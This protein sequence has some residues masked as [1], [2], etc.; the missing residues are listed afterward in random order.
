MKRA[1]AL[2]LICGFVLLATS[3]SCAAFDYPDG[4]CRGARV[5]SSAAAP[6]STQRDCASCVE[7]SCCDPV[8]KCEDDGPS[9]L[10]PL[11]AM[12]DCVVEGG[13]KPS[14]EAKC[15]PALASSD[16]AKSTYTCMRD[17]CGARCLL[18]ACHVDPA[19][20]LILHSKCDQC[21]SDS[22]CA[23]LNACHQNRACKLTSECIVSRCK[24]QLA[25]SL[26]AGA[27]SRIG[28][29][30]LDEDPICTKNEPPLGAF[31]EG[32]ERCVV[33][34]IMEFGSNDPTAAIDPHLGAYCLSTKIFQCAI[35]SGCG[36]DCAV[37]PPDA[38]LG[39]ASP[40]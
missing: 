30:D 19:A 34:C 28:R 24:Y 32:A 1:W 14:V 17:R 15:G 29:L 37:P 26:E 10:E 3:I 4:S 27:S 7:Q 2:C 25:S 33:E 22:C 31:G 39:D 40:E 38:G 20:V 16:D 8:G 12:V 5:A 21:F 11:R 35:R 23:E 9:C 18:P 6:P 13:P 36:R